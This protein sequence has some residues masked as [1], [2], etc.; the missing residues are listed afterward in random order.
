MTLKNRLYLYT[1]MKQIVK[2]AC[3]C[4]CLLP[5]LAF[6]QEPEV[7]Y[8]L[9]PD[10]SPVMYPDEELLVPK[11]A[12]GTTVETA[13]PDHVNNA[14]TL[15]FPPVFNQAGGSCSAAS[16]IGY[17]F[18]HEMN[19]Y[20]G[21]NGKL[22]ANRYPSHFV[23]LMTNGNSG[24]YALV[25]HVG[26]PN[27]AVYG[28]ITYSHLFGNQTAFQNNF[29]WMQGYDKWY[30]AMFNRMLQ[31]AHFPLSLKTEEGRVALKRWLYN[32]NGDTSYKSGGVAG[33]GVG[34]N[35]KWGNIPN[36]PTNDEIGVS[37]KKYVQSWGVK[38]N[39]ALTIVGYDDRIEFDLDQ[40]GIK[41][42]KEKDEVG[43]WIIVNSWGSG[44]A[45]NGFIY[46]PYAYA[47]KTFKK[48]ANGLYFGGHWWFPEVF[49]V[50]KDYRPLRTIKVEM[51]Y[52]HRS[53][54]ALSVGIATD[55][56]A[57]TPEKTIPLHH[58]QYAGDGKR[59]KTNPAPAVPML[60]KWADGKLHSEPMEFGYDLTELS[61]YFNKNQTLKYFFIVETRDWAAGS[62][63]IH[64]AAI[65]DYEFDREGK[66]IPFSIDSAGVDIVNKGGRT[67]ISTIVSGESYYEPQN[68]ILSKQ[69][70][71]WQTPLASVHKIMGYQIFADDILLTTLSADAN[72]YQLPEE[73]TAITY[74]VATLYEKEVLSPKV[75][76]N[77][78]VVNPQTNECIR[79]EHGGFSVPH[80]FDSKYDEA[81]IEFWIRPHSLISYNQGAGPGWN[82][83]FKMHS[84]ATGN[85]V[86]GWDQ[87]YRAS[88]PD[89]TLKV[90]QWTHLA[91]TVKQNVM[92]LYVNGK[93]SANVTAEGYSGIGGFEEFNFGSNDNENNID[94]DIDEFRIWNYARS[95]SQIEKG[96][97]IEYNGNVM[98]KGLLAYYKGATATLN[99][100]TLLR[101][102]AGVN[103]ARL[104]NQSS[105]TIVADG[106]SMNAPTGDL[107]I[108]INTTAEPVYCGIPVKMTA[109]YS[110]TANDICW[111]APAAG[112]ESLHIASPSLTFAKVGKYPVTATASN[113]TG[114]Q[115]SDIYEVNVIAPPAPNAEFNISRAKI[116]AGE[117]V[118][119]IA[120]QSLVGYHYEWD[121]P[122]A[123]TEKGNTANVATTYATNGHY[124]VK[125][126]VTAP[127]GRKAAS[128]QEIDVVAVAP[129]AQFDI[130]PSWV[131]KGES[132]SIKDL[133]KYKPTNWQ[134]IFHSENKDLVVNQQ[135]GVIVSTT[136]GVYDVS[137]Q[138]SNEKGNDQMVL[139]RGLTVCNADSKNGLFFTSSA[140]LVRIN[141]TPLKT[142]QQA[143]TID[144]WMNPGEI[145]A[146][147]NGIGQEGAFMI[148]TAENGAFNL[149]IGQQ[150]YT[151][152]PGL[153]L[154]NAWH[155][156]AIIFNA[157]K[158]QFYR[159]GYMVSSKMTTTTSLPVCRSITIGGT[160]A[161]FH[162]EIDEFRIWLKALDETTLRQFAN[163]P[164]EDVAQ[165]VGNHQLALYY[166][167]NQSGGN[168]LDRTTHHYDGQR[169]EFGPD[170]DAWGLSQGV[171]CL[172]FEN[173]GAQDISAQQLKNY[174]RPFLTDGNKLINPV[175]APRFYA[176]AD[177]TL[178]NATISGDV[179]T[180]VHVDKQ[181]NDCFT[182]TSGW[183]GFGDLNN[184]KVYQTITLPAGAYTFTADYAEKNNA[185]K[186]GDSYLVVAIGQGLPDTDQMHTAWA[187]KAMSPK[188]KACNS[189]QVRFVL[190][191]N[192][193]VSL[194]FVINMSGQISAS[195][196]Q[197]RLLRNE[198]AFL[199]VQTE[200][201]YDLTIGAEGATTLY[202]PYA[203]ALPEGITAYTVTEIKANTAYI[204]P[205]TSGV[206]P[207]ATGVI[208]KGQP[209]NYHFI[210]VGTD[211]KAHSLLMGVATDTPVDNN[212]HY[213]QLKDNLFEVITEDVLKANRAY[214]TMTADD[215]PTTYQVE[216]V[217]TG[218][219][220]IEAM[221]HS[222]KVYDLSGRQVNPP[223]KGVYICNGK[224][225]CR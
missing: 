28:G 70:L 93:P 49:K 1:A 17:M 103:H 210:S 23:W 11:L 71:S 201:G 33:V 36:T 56:H 179:T 209:G 177:W 37:G 146:G 107:A 106:L 40:N 84:N 53:E 214:L 83:G 72:S 96:K 147:G 109:N 224:K 152:E 221:K 101:D 57:T 166:D 129:K 222:A 116:S 223:F 133:S 182:M 69:Q 52:S 30:S 26:V 66:E 193:E 165:A 121:M 25:Q 194:G 112:V 150:N 186:C 142:A 98:P 68:L 74:S 124:K 127:D 159:D 95:E 184:H 15:Y 12:S 190:K 64:H 3:L 162:G 140:A 131:I 78:P 42:E 82:D 208:V 155:H 29:G 156:Y 139:P 76:V 157:G 35:G 73:T 21:T 202:L 2:S 128:E 90:G 171:F 220:Y 87:T 173:D 31:P 123:M 115:V 119:F 63:K 126:T 104:F 110:E 10:Y 85:F 130:S 191:E 114:Q 108:S 149:T 211:E 111:R 6:A 89:G 172:N 163:N 47:G 125:L 13:L 197:F 134:W 60:G 189:N 44:F 217:P 132:V 136:P 207:A 22:M 51:D 138:V 80:I 102:F 199:D 137:L 204:S 77:A 105:S 135:E 212:K 43:A 14:K 183:D 176:I 58:F 86:A 187:Y 24:K 185:G 218:I 196:E 168:V 120:T 100:K 94:A 153:V 143:I 174:K 46:C 160:K 180:A 27:A 4:S 39:H 145:T 91:I 113:T 158:L 62:G 188:S 205:L 161:P 8:Q 81:T 219:D 48:D 192:T 32:H 170:G 61:S 5:T 178:E 7:D 216:M 45:N 16:R 151:T 59:G 175:Q 65:I 67:L 164:I 18:T 167:F 20:R 92:V 122:G 34:I 117:H 41:G 38:F 88:T 99:K 154:S 195:I 169:Q 54:I 141:N 181:K 55:L 9:Y 50:R 206:I 19:S 118:T 75:S 200:G 203:T 148:K 97:L 198:V 225:I 213:Y 79:I 215:A 144:W